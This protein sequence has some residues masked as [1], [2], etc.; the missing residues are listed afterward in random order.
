MDALADVVD[1]DTAGVFVE[2][3]QGEAGV[4]IPPDGF[5]R[6]IRDICDDAGALMIVDEVQTGMGRTGKWLAIQHT[7]VAPDIVTLA[8][9]LARGFPIG[10][11]V[12]REGEFKSE[13]GSTLREGRSPA[14]ALA[15]IGVIE[16]SSRRPG[17]G[18]AVQEAHPQPTGRGLMIPYRSATMPEVAICAGTGIKQSAADGIPADPP[19][20]ITGHRTQLSGH[21]WCA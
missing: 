9:G 4:L 7:G 6:G 14:A 15:T 21:Q 1:K 20:V 18:R 5:F 19:L 3:I 11:L 10:A 12:A 13:H 16:E 17:E 2:P 8:K